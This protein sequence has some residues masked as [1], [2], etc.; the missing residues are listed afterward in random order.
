MSP[1]VAVASLGY[2]NRFR[3][4]APEV[5][6]RYERQGTELLRTDQVGTVTVRS[7]GESYR[8]ET[9]LP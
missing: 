9:F 8:V 5:V 4:P 3:F 7:N 6:D 1:Q 2:Q